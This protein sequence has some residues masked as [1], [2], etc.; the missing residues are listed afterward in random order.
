MVRFLKLILFS[1]THQPKQLGVAPKVLE[2]H[3]VFGKQSF[4]EFRLQSKVMFGYRVFTVY[5]NNFTSKDKK[6][7]I[8][9]L[10]NEC[11]LKDAVT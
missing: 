3:E 4:D 6:S 1:E 2:N 7:W 10:N 5:R 8:F 11:N 9:I